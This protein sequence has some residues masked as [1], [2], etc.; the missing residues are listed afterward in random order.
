MHPN[1]SRQDNPQ[2]CNHEEEISLIDIILFLKSAYKPA[3]FFGALGLIVALTYLWIAPNKYEASAQI[4]MAQIGTGGEKN[5]NPLGV[6]IEEPALLIS[7][8][9]SPTSF[10]PV[11]IGACGLQNEA[12][13]SLLLSKT[14]KLTIPKGVGNVVDLK[15][16]GTS[17]ESALSCANA[18]F[19]LIQS[20]Q[21]QILSP[22]IE[23]AK[24]KLADDQERLQKAK[25]LVAKSDKSGQAMSAAYL[26][27]RDEIRY[28]LDDITSLK[29]IATANQ[30]RAT[31]LIAPI[32]ANDK[33]VS[34]KKGVALAA[35]L[36]A[37]LFLGVL[38]ALGRK[39][40]ATFKSALTTQ[41][42]GAL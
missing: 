6:N 7:R 22:Y 21:A 4:A 35:G 9:S 5:L 30:N 23:E 1:Q 31:H 3:L 16:T 38:V 36:F 29:N 37:G 15:T 18:I 19:E 12:D 8:L 33:P 14:I 34:P 24:I 11:V 40:W 17:S 10:T 2:E 28:L 41:D 26:S 39:M 32:Y 27:T 13:A 20:T 25:D 42:R